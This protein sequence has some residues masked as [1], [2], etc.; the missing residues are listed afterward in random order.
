MP[1]F[2]APVKTY[3]CPCPSCKIHQTG[4]MGLY[5]QAELSTDRDH[6]AQISTFPFLSV[7]ERQQQDLPN[8]ECSIHRGVPRQQGPGL[9]QLRRP[10]RPPGVR[11]S[12]EDTKCTARPWP[13]SSVGI[14]SRQTHH[15]QPL[16]MHIQVNADVALWGVG[17]AWR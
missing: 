16:P 6:S 4:S 3:S 2:R 9:T 5:I 7:L 13:C 14:L 10:R 17:W 15:P 8:D 11:H 12:M 1:L